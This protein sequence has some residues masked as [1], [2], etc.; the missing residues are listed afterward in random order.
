M[1]L[2]KKTTIL[3]SELLHKR[4]IQLAKQN[5]I[6]LGELVRSACEKQYG[7]ISQSEAEK[8]LKEL[9]ELSLPVAE[10]TQLKTQL[11]PTS[12]ELMP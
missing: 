10:M 9:S 2:T 12:D 5:N 4:L 11:N 7:L 1:E 6:S 3:F 8:A